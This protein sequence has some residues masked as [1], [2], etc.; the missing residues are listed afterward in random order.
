MKDL[1][2]EA[3]RKLKIEKAKNKQRAETNPEKLGQR[4]AKLERRISEEGYLEEQRFELKQKYLEQ[5][6][7]PSPLEEET[8][9]ELEKALKNAIDQTKK[10]SSKRLEI[11]KN[12]LDQTKKASSDKLKID[13]SDKLELS[14]VDFTEDSRPSSR[15]LKAIN[16]DWRAK[17]T[18]GTEPEI[19]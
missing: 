7:H 4:I 14:D 3:I 13:E 5:Y 11:L 2:I 18:K 17:Y 6:E 19:L 10:A 1:S 15:V 8:M 12:T 16:V 9:L